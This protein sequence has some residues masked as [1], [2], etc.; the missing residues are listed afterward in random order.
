MK[1]TDEQRYTIMEVAGDVKL[2]RIIPRAEYERYYRN[3][4]RI[5][6]KDGDNMLGLFKLELQKEGDEDNLVYLAEERG[7]K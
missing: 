2:C 3:D 1:E 5:I 6:S 4:D 7:Q